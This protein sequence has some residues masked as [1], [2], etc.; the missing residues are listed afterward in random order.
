MSNIMLNEQ[1][2]RHQATE[3]D[4]QAEKYYMDF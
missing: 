4:P 2:K 1:Y 3:N